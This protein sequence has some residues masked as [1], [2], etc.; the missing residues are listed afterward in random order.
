VNASTTTIG[1]RIKISQP[2][3]FFGFLPGIPEI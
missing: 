1:T 2:W 3:V